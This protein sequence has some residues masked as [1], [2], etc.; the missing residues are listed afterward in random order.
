MNVAED[1]PLATVRTELETVRAGLSLDTAI[2]A[3]D[4][5]GTAF[6]KF[7]VQGVDACGNRGVLVHVSE[8]TATGELSAIVALA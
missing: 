1:K 5:T 7:T 3:V 4:P 6:V 2:E 8:D